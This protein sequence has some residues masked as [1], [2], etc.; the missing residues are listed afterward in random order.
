[1][2]NLDPGGEIG[3][4]ILEKKIPFDGC[5]ASFI[6]LKIMRNYITFRFL[7]WLLRV[8]RNSM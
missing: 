7:K 2:A 3:V 5:F 8:T 1:M 6:Q 4:Y